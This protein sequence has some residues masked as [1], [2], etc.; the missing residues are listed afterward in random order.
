MIA[1]RSVVLVSLSRMED[2]AVRM[3]TS[4]HEVK[5]ML[6]FVLTGVEGWAI[7]G[8]LVRDSIAE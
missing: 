6:Q 7:A 3:Y 4:A 1:I 8:S 2:R 5:G